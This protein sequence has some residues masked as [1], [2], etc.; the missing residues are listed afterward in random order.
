MLINS[1]IAAALNLGFFVNAALTGTPQVVQGIYT[2][3]NIIQ[4]VIFEY[5]L[6]VSTIGTYII[7]GIQSASSANLTYSLCNIYIDVI[8]LA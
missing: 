6:T 5:V 3:A 1:T 4:K 8:Q 7:F 2:A